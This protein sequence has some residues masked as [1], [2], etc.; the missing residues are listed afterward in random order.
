VAI[1]Q[2]HDWRGA[3]VVSRRWLGDHAAYRTH[4]WPA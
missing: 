4:T 2:H 3:D 1:A